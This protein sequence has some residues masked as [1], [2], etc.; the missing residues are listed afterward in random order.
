MRPREAGMAGIIEDGQR[1]AWLRR[2]VAAAALLFAAGCSGF[3]VYPGSTGTGTGGNA[4]GD[5]VYV[6]NATTAT[7]SGFS[8]GTGTLTAVANSPYALPVSPTAIAVT[9]ANSIVYVAGGTAIYAYAIESGGVLTVLN[10]GSPVAAATVVA[11]DI[12]PDGRW[13]FA[14]DQNGSTIE[15][16]QINSSTGALTS[17]TT[18]YA[19]G[20]TVV[21]RAIKVSPNGQFVF[22]A[23]GTAGDLVYPF[24]T[25]T[26]GL[27][28]PLLLSPQAN[29]S[30]N[31]LA[32]SPGST[33]LFIARSGTGGG[34]AVY[35]IGLGG[36]LTEATGSPF[37]AG[38]QPFSVAV[39]KAGTDVYVANQLDSTV[40]GFSIGSNG[41][42]TALSGSP[43]ASG[44]AVTALAI[45]NSG[46][47]LLAAARN[48][49]PDL[50]LYSF[51]TS[52]AGKLDL[53]ASTATGTDPTLPVALATT[54]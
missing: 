1:T 41:A 30:D 17:Q 35:S 33:Y 6:A 27:S 5:Y 18:S 47:Y 8:V 7:V 32:V 49:A 54:H 40:S 15:E 11:L 9:P 52:T 4:T 28:T 44:S 21:P 25:A 51:D 43:Y 36:A 37:T 48:G 2:T 29:T 31:A 3:F 46:N 26:G 39:N 20:G 45:D 14:L 50:S 16:Y 19:A 34:L 22:V 23:L 12:S 42:L 10:S 38:T 53:A 13:L 24:N